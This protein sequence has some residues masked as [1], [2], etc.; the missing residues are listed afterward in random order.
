M[1]V[2]EL[3]MVTMQND[4]IKEEEEMVADVDKASKLC[5]KMELPKQ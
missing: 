1:K 3:G 2:K 4:G 5:P